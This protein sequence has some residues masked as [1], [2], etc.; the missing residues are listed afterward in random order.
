M[1]RDHHGD[2]GGAQRSLSLGFETS[3]DLLCD[4]EITHDLTLYRI[5]ADSEQRLLG[6]FREL[7]DPM[8]RGAGIPLALGDSALRGREG[9]VSG[10]DG[11]AFAPEGYEQRW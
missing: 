9:P 1:N 3:L 5:S 4:I 8:L 10:A 7:E 6:I 2:A 11:I